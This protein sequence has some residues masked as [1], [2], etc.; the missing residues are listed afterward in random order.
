M[1]EPAVVIPE[2]LDIIQFGAPRKPEDALAEAELV[3]KA[4]AARAQRLDLW[5][6][7]GPSRHLKIE[8]WQML[9]MMYRV[10]AGI[11][12]TKPVKFGEHDG[13][14]ATAE[15]IYVPTRSRISTADAMCLTDEE[16]WDLRPVYEG[17]GADRKHVDDIQVPYFQLRSMAQTRACSKVLANLFKFIA[18][19]SGFAGTPAEEMTGREAHAGSSGNGQAPQR[20]GKAAPTDPISEPQMGRL[21]AIANT[22]NKSDDAVGVVLEHFKYSTA[23]GVRAAAAKIQRKDYD[24]IVNEVM[25]P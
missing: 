17:K 7:I 4:F 18:L 24:A 15:A 9:G 1:S 8:G 22:H 10:T 23:D 20:T 2:A 21:F 6:Q 19:M 14:E 13:W 3:A 25:R 11:V 16:Q 12:A 5:K